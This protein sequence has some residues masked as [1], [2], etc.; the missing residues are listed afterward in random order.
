MEALLS[1]QGD[2]KV[3]YAYL[4]NFFEFLYRHLQMFLLYQQSLIS[5]RAKAE[6]ALKEIGS[7]VLHSLAIFQDNM[8]ER[9]P[10][11]MRSAEQAFAALHSRQL[12]QDLQVF[13][14]SV[15]ITLARL[16]SG[17]GSDKRVSMNDRADLESLL[18]QITDM[19]RI[20]MVQEMPQSKVK[21]EA[22]A[23]A[24]AM[25]VDTEKKEPAA[26]SLL[27]A[28]EEPASPVKDDA[29]PP[30]LVMSLTSSPDGSGG[31]LLRTSVSTQLQVLLVQ[32]HAYQPELLQA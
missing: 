26:S 4:S 25:N 9:A 20:I 6:A 7:Q 31:Q 19:G 12:A 11:K 3:V 10:A 22:A 21:K 15:R 16:S 17:K 18:A 1:A 32:K 24:D 2:R 28:K 30:P 13:V 23:P 14:R 5:K 29:P 27:P 8:A